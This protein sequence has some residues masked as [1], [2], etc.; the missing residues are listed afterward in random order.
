[1]NIPNI[2]H[3]MHENVN[4]MSR[5]ESFCVDRWRHYHPNHRIMFHTDD[6]I[7]RD[8][9]KTYPDIIDVF[10]TATGIVKGQIGRYLAMILHGGTYADVDVCPFTC[11]N[12]W[13]DKNDKLIT[14]ER[15]KDDYEMDYQFH[16]IKNHP[17]WEAML[18][19]G[20]SKWKKHDKCF[21]N[22]DGYRLCVF[23]TVGVHHYHNHV[24]RHDRR[25]MRAPLCSSYE[26]NWGI[27]ECY[28]S[29]FSSETWLPSE[30][31][32]W[33]KHD[34]PNKYQQEEQ[35]FIEKIDKLLPK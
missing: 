13:I 28:T 16:S 4:S 33:N 11:I 32:R 12:N 18:L 19:D 20:V 23:E 5:L 8:I 29:H 26:C 14:V 1:M 9:E 30:N 6:T 22:I 24:Q 10:D 35:R 17:V 25:I 21:D 3:L 34:Y 2:I 7:R 15:N 27:D 31:R